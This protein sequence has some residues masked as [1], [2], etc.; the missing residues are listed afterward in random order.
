MILVV[1]GTCSGK[2]TYARALMEKN[3]WQEADLALDVQEELWDAA[4]GALKATPQLLERLAA[5]RVVTCAEVGGGVVP[6]DAGERAW[7][8]EVG[9]MSCELAGRAECVVRTVCG[10]P[11]ALK[12]PLP[13]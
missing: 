8:E 5:K 2:K 13:C 6:L 12:G 1:G 3:G 9:R 10:I 11:I 4:R 7:R